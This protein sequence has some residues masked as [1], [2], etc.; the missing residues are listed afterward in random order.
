MEYLPK[1]RGITVYADGAREGQP[2]TS[3]P[4]IDALNETGLIED[5]QY[6]NCNSGLCAT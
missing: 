3:I 2:M 6:S 4:I 5:T 1:L